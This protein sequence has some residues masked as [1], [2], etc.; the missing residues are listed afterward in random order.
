MFLGEYEH[1]L[2][3]KGRLIVPAKFREGLG[4]K[5]VLSIGFDGCLYIYP[6]E[7]WKKFDEKLDAL[8]MTNA[9]ARQLTRLF[10]GNADYVEI[11]KQGRFMVRE[12]LRN[13]AGIT[14][15]AVFVGHSNKIEL[16]SKEKYEEC[17]EVSGIKMDNLADSMEDQGFIF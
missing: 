5:F 4:E 2:D 15:T 16:W 17:F 11:D 6:E 1:N 13:Y 10:R 12:K 14:K 8:P 3:A 7:E 9:K